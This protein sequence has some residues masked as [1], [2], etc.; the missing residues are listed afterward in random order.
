MLKKQF[1]KIICN[2]RLGLGFVLI[3][4]NTLFIAAIFYP[5]GLIKKHTS[6]S[7]VSKYCLSYLHK[8]G[9]LWIKINYVIVSL[10][11]GVKWK[12]NGLENLQQL[13][14]DTWYLLMSNHQSWNDVLVLQFALHKY[15]PFQKYLVKEKMRKFPVM[16]FVWEALDNP[17]LKRQNLSKKNN[18]SSESSNDNN[19]SD[20]ELIKKMSKKFKILPT[21][22]V[23][24]LEGTRFT[25][26][27]H[28]EQNSPFKNLLK[29]KSG[30]VAAILEEL[31]NQIT[32]IID[33]S[34]CY[35]PRKMSF[36]DLFSGKINN[37]IVNINVIPIP[38]WLLQAYHSHANY[39]EYKVK[40]ESW[41]NEI[42]NKKD[43]L[44]SEQCYN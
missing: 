16:G 4:I 14:K 13:P 12:I 29:P 1:N 23:S 19:Q 44:I 15:L 7:T 9:S 34:I 30:G 40:F 25:P 42:W 38:E 2:I 6:S 28:Q 43:K 11:S 33:V 3:T 35:S 31:H 20:V 5:A 26:E 22:V 10:V 32:A 36:K 37:I 8:V 41:V 24:F 18:S 17:F 39:S 21:T 27:K